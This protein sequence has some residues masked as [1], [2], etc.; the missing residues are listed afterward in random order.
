MNACIPSISVF[1][2]ALAL[3]AGAAENKSAMAAGKKG[4]VK[5]AWQAERGPAALESLTMDFDDKGVVKADGQLVKVRA[6]KTSPVMMLAEVVSAMDIDGGLAFKLKPLESRT[7]ST[8]GKLEKK[9]LSGAIINVLYEGDWGL[10]DKNDEPT[11]NPKSA[12][13]VVLPFPNDAELEKTVVSWNECEGT[14]TGNYTGYP[15][16]RGRGMADVFYGFLRDNILSCTTAGLAGV[17]GG[18]ATKIHIVHD[19]TTADSAHNRKSLHAAGR[20][21]DIQTVTITTGNGQRSFDFRITTAK[22]DSQDRKFYEGFRQCWHKIHMSR[23]CPH[24]ASG[25]PVGTIGWEDKRHKGHHLHTSMPFC[26]NTNHWFETSFGDDDEDTD[27][28]LQK[29]ESDGE[30]I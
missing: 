28:I 20:A 14:V 21:V 18:T 15:C 23:G 24:R 2:T 13:K 1:F 8:D 19:G 4:Q 25:N 17:G 12:V 11:D 16:S 27:V 7:R 22:P 6:G 5:T 30:D 10:I 26:P 9:Q 29:N 3:L